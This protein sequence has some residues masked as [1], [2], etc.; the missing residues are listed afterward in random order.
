[1]YTSGAD[2]LYLYATQCHVT[3]R[4]TRNPGEQSEKTGTEN[5]TAPIRHG[6]VSDALSHTQHRLSLQEQ[7]QPVCKIQGIQGSTK[8]DRFILD[9]DNRRR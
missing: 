6:R 1:M 5:G 8:K 2:D 3:H 9:L 7:V 4:H